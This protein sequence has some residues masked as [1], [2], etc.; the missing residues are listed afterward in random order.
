MLYFRNPSSS[1]S[2]S[3]C[4]RI[5]DASTA[6][7]LALTMAVFMATEKLTAMAMV[8]MASESVSLGFTRFEMVNNLGIIL[9]HISEF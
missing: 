5:D 9:L 2:S 4:K 3:F 7:G 8:V 6:T 1:C